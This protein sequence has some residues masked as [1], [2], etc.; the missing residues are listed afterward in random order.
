MM[1]IACGD[2]SRACASIPR[3]KP[4]IERGLAPDGPEWGR[5]TASSLGP[6]GYGVNL[7]SGAGSVRWDHAWVLK[8]GVG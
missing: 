5:L 1:G 8:R 4:L 6:T 3:S 7:G 2:L